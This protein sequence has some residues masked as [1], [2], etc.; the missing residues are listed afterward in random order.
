MV[1][2]SLDY[3]GYASTDFQYRGPNNK[4]IG[5]QTERLSAFESLMFCHDTKTF[6]LVT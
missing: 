5:H 1:F 3:I 2:D 4:L 6:L